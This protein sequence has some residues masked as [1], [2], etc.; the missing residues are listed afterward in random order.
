MSKT[1][2]VCGQEIVVPEGSGGG[3]GGE[4]TPADI[5][6]LQ[7]QLNDRYTKEE[8]DAIVDAISTGEFVVVDELP[9]EGEAKNIYLVAKTGGGYKEYL[10]VNDAWE[11]I[12]D[13]DI[14]LSDYATKSELTELSEAVE[15]DITDLK[16]NK[17]DKSD[18]DN[19]ATTE[20]LDAK[21][22]KTALANY[23]TTEAV[24]IALAAKANTSD[25]ED[26]LTCEDLADCETITQMNTAIDAK[27]DKTE[28]ADYAKTSDLDG[29]AKE[30][31]LADYA[32]A[33]DLANK[34][35]KSELADYAK[36][37]DLADYAKESD[38]ADY[39]K[40]ADVTTALADKAD[41]TA[42]ADMLTCENIE[43]C[44]VVSDMA[45]DI[46]SKANSADVYTKTETDTALADK[47][48]S[49][50]VYT[51]T[52]A[53]NLL[54]DKADKA[55]TYTKTETDNLIGA[56][57]NVT[58]E[59]VTELPTEGES[60]KIYLVP[61]EGGQAPNVYDE[62]VYAN[63]AFEKIGDTE[64]DLSGYATTEAMNTALA[65]KADKSELSDYAKTADV[66]TALDDKADKSAIADM[67][68]CD[69]IEDCDV[70]SELQEKVKLNAD[71]IASKQNT[72]IAGDNIDI[73]GNTISATDTTYDLLQVTTEGS[74]LI[75]LMD[76]DNNPQS[77]SIAS[78]SGLKIAN[79]GV[80]GAVISADTDV[81]ALKSDVYT[82]TET[83]TKLDDKQDKA[84]ATSVTLSGSGWNS[85]SQTVSASDVTADNNVIVTPAPASHD[86][87]GDAG[88]RA[89]AQASGS[90]TFE[91]T[92]E[93]TSDVTV[94]LL[95][96]N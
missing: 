27:A 54:D 16:T 38:L 14:D 51:K 49:A 3:G 6:R 48:N 36:T 37:T 31:D 24:D 53:D 76:S 55:T 93:P 9:A 59:V 58:I 5:A 84:I 77:A 19:Y 30:S 72:L 86:A 45:D 91:A 82:K 32:K 83:D 25:L 95:I 44:D 18:L 33:S 11:E 73:T 4:V 87:Y 28:L 80:T 75:T 66:N 78:G 1:I 94:N 56:I 68:T 50:D 34:A 67:L 41:K 35:D 2:D 64:I 43:D 96:F 71:D 10:Y 65:D 26:L 79:S 39:A 61:K 57:E 21:A 85:G 89:T 7:E 92:T 47:A 90:L 63:D 88:I 8:T 52:E 62:Y 69:N 70:I 60:N 13:T 20:A 46:S 22:D 15:G 40:T 81:L 17:A 42:I 29:Y 23:A 12:G 74:T